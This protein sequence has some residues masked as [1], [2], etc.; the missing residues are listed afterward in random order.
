MQLREKQNEIQAIVFASGEPIELSRLSQAVELDEKE[1]LGLIANINDL[2][3]EQ[4]IPFELVRLQESVQLCTR[5]QYAPLI[6]RALTLRRN[7]P[8]SQAALEVLAIVAYNQP[9]TKAFVEQVRGVDSSSTVNSLVEKGL[10]EE[11]GR[12][13]LPGRP[14]S[15]KTTSNFLRCFSLGSLDEL[16][17]LESAGEDEGGE[18]RQLDGQLGFE[19]TLPAEEALPFGEGEEE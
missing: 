13:E 6:R 14:I 12:L 3:R 17:S 11:A 10:I 1:T 16:P 8:L 15:Y 19:E 9:V 4:E 5:S 18:E 7:T 2:Y